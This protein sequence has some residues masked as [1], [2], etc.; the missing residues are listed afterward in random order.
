MRI[1]AVLLA[2]I[3][4][5]GGVSAKA[6][7]P[8]SG[9][10]ISFDAPSVSG[11]DVRD[12]EKKLRV[13]LDAVCNWWGP[14]FKGPFAIEVEDDRGSSMALIPAWRGQRG[15]MIFRA[16]NRGNFA[17]THETTHVFAP[18]ANRFLAEGLAVFA[19]E[20]LKGADAYPNFGRD[21][22]RAARALAEKADFAAL[23][24]MA[25][26]KRLRTDDLDSDEAYIVAGSFMR[27][28]IERREAIGG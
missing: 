28:L 4:S 23:D 18:N 1:I 11:G 27:F 12:L 21:L 2:L 8:C 19:H 7:S 3:L 24:D 6:E 22:H 9:A 15:H 14:T 5:L 20:H 17:I 25:T 10:W 26:P 13:A 16:R